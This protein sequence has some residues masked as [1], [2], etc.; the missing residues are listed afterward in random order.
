MKTTNYLLG[1]L[2]AA[3]IFS[4]ARAFAQSVYPLDSP[5]AGAVNHLI[6]RYIDSEK[7]FKESAEQVK[8]A[9]LK[10]RFMK[11]SEE[12]KKFREDLQAQLA[13]IGE[14]Y[15]KS[16]SMAGALHR[17]WIDTKS[18]VSQDDLAVLNAVRTGEEE[19]VKSYKNLLGSDLPE[20]LRDPIRQQY[21]E[22]LKSYTWVIGE[23]KDRS[24]EKEAAKR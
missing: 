10:A 7:G 8:D 6:E 4:G 1:V 3:L 19:A 22:V 16:G 23:I 2:A 5:T 15:D 11:Q 13:A 9:D 24:K 14:D 21:E 20:S 18:A 12:R 17:A